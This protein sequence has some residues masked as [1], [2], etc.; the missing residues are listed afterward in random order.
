MA[1]CLKSIKAKVYRVEVSSMEG[2]ALRPFYFIL[3][4]RRQV[5]CQ[6][7]PLRQLESAIYYPLS[8]TV[9]Y[10]VEASHVFEW[11]SVNLCTNSRTHSC[12]L[13]PVDHWKGKVSLVYHLKA[14]FIWMNSGL[15]IMKNFV[16]E[17]TLCNTL[18]KCPTLGILEANFSLFYIYIHI[19]HIKYL[20]CCSWL[21]FT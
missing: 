1:L 17:N 20:L 15:Q 12:Y 11:P 4:N 9:R 21:L 5:H 18:F 6:T 2:W 19:S 14:V 7:F 13:Q 3:S 10:H 8:M 16:T